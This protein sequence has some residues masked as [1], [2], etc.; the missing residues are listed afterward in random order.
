MMISKGM[1][2]EGHVVLKGAK[3]NTY[4]L[5]ERTPKE[6]DHLEDLEVDRR[7]ILKDILKR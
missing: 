5:L 6:R 2:G 1:T 3:G 4:S 7:T